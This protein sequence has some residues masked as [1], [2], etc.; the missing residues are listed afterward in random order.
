MRPTGTCWKRIAF[1][2][3]RVHPHRKNR[4]YWSAFQF[5]VILLA[6]LLWSTVLRILLRHQPFSLLHSMCQ[7]QCCH[8]DFVKRLPLPSLGDLGTTGIY[9]PYSMTCLQ[10]SMA[11]A[12]LPLGHWLKASVE[13]VWR[14]STT[15]ACQISRC[16]GVKVDSW[17][18]LLLVLVLLCI[19]PSSLADSCSFAAFQSKLAQLSSSH[20]Q[21]PHS[22]VL[23]F[24][25]QGQIYS[26]DP[27]NCH[28]DLLPSSSFCTIS[29]CLRNDPAYAI[30]LLAGSDQLTSGVALIP[31]FWSP[32][33][34][35]KRLASSSYQLRFCLE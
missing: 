14:D 9:M 25:S 12:A 32:G 11:W 4:H 16:T 6:Y 24:D 5:W 20:I 10:R 19:G 1:R 3:K 26:I 17:L 34:L 15:S 22:R 28:L 13:Q 29:L 18:K 31:W 30:V 2:T 7:S 27:P 21:G 23:Q 8:R 33:A 35:V